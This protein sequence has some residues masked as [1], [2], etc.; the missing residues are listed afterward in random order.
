MLGD[1]GHRLKVYL[2][3]QPRKSSKNKKILWNEF[4]LRYFPQSSS[5]G[6]GGGE[7]RTWLTSFVLIL[8]CGWLFRFSV[9]WGVGRREALIILPCVRPL[10]V[11]TWPLLVT[12]S[13]SHVLSSRGRF[14]QPMTWWCTFT[15]CYVALLCLLKAINH[16]L[17]LLCFFMCFLVDCL[18]F[19]RRPQ[20]PRNP[21]YLVYLCISH[22]V[23]SGMWKACE[24]ISAD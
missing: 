10:K 9:A 6:G 20:K 14:L 4:D 18:L 24:K 7:S 5:Y 15:T 17:Q 11:S 22:L 2:E 19:T 16:S 12:V 21:V 23:V 3:D 1:S 13:A 8:S